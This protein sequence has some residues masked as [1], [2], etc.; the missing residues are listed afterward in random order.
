MTEEKTVQVFVTK[1]ALTQG[2]FIASGK[3]ARTTGIYL[4]GRGLSDTFLSETDYAL[5]REDALDQAKKKASV[6]ITSAEKKLEKLRVLLREPL[7]SK[8]GL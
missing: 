5:T 6:A 2:I 7:F 8:D 1:Y 3:Y 4:V